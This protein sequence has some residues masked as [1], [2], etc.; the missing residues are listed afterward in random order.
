MIRKMTVQTLAMIAVLEA[1]FSS[2]RILYADRTWWNMILINFTQQ[3]YNMIG[4][5]YFKFIIKL[6]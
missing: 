3:K 6:Y 5:S 2:C 1:P 4:I